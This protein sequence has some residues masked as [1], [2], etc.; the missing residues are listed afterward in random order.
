MECV[1]YK[2]INIISIIICSSVLML[3]ELMCWWMIELMCCGCCCEL[4]WMDDGWRWLRG[5]LWYWLL[6]IIIM[7]MLLNDH[8][9]DEAELVLNR[10]SRFCNSWIHRLLSFILPRIETTTSPLYNLYIHQCIPRYSPAQNTCT[11]TKR[12]SATC[13]PGPTS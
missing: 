7:I 8:R 3:M 13:G 11:A 9:T 12:T 6:C 2:A 10:N 4:W 1:G 5:L